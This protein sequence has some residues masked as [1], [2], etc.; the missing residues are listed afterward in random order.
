MSPH[1]FC[2]P[3][4]I[5]F[6]TI[7]SLVLLLSVCTGLNI[8]SATVPLASFWISSSLCHHCEYILYNK[9]TEPPSSLLPTRHCW[10]VTNCKKWIDCLSE[11]A[12]RNYFSKNLRWHMK[13]HHNNLSLFNSSFEGVFEL[14]N[15]KVQG[16]WILTRFSG[17]Q[18]NKD[19]GF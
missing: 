7:L 11:M 14:Q 10:N 1:I 15:E 17:K 4:F 16:R 8:S 18:E 13:K 9:E 19:R 3:V 5:V 2:F 12:V 6:L